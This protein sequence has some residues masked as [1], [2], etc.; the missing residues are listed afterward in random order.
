MEP[1]IMFLQKIGADIKSIR[2]KKLIKQDTLAKGVGL[3]K[4]E[5][6]RIENGKREIGVSKLAAIA[7]ILGTSI[8]A[9]LET[10]KF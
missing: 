6:S 4:S 2:K 1:T 3:T 5:I 7:G 10:D 8:E 9:I